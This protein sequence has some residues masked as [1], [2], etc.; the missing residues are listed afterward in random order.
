M[1]SDIERGVA[2]LT[3]ENRRESF[4]SLS[5]LSVACYIFVCSS[6][7]ELLS[8]WKMIKKN[9]TSSASGLQ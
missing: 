4:L 7:F 9:L 5:S 2:T 6:F 8:Y 1:T 3:S